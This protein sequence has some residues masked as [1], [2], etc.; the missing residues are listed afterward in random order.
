MS[1]LQVGVSVQNGVEAIVHRVDD[2]WDW[3]YKDH[4]ENCIFEAEA[5]KNHFPAL[6]PGPFL[7]IGVAFSICWGLYLA[8]WMC[9]PARGPMLAIHPLVT[10]LNTTCP[11]LNLTFL[12]LIAAYI[13]MHKYLESQCN[14]WSNFFNLRIFLLILVSC[15]EIATTSGSS[16][17]EWYHGISIGPLERERKTQPSKKYPIFQKYHEGSA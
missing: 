12:C 14:Q 16:R 4:G 8:Q 3:W 15:N 17:L 5:I 11:D 13:H 6:L 10:E 2:V 7:L 9:C 1:P